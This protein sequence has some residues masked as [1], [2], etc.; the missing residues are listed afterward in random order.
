M[1]KKKAPN[2]NV[3]AQIT[4]D[5]TDKDQQQQVKN[6]QEHQP[7]TII[8]LEQIKVRE[9]DTRPLHESHVADLAESITVL[10]LLEPLVLD[11][12]YRLLAGGHRLAAIQLVKETNTKAYQQHFPNNLVPVRI[13]AF[14][15]VENPDL[16]LQ[17]E[18][19]E[20]EH[21]RDYTP[22]EVKLMAD[23]LQEQ[24]YKRLKGRP[25]QGE[26]SLVQA[27]AFVVNKSKRTIERYLQED[28][29]HDGQESAT[30]VA[31]SSERAALRKTYKDLKS[32]QKALQEEPQTP[33]RQSLAKK[34]PSMM[35]L[36]DAALAEIEGIEKEEQQ[37]S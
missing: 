10:G 21:R 22:T 33:K 1:A 29:N 11:L 26:K 27:L 9:Q 17:V 18:V 5:M 19:A 24:G 13:M 30:R 12:R 36:I 37:T 20:N 8:P 16:A 25:A 6:A 4:N 32:W 34:L 28:K 35:R 2:W 23:R 3:V 15:A 7:K 14:D 31:L